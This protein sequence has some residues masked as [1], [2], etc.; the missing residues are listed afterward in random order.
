MPEP[1]WDIAPLA[2]ADCDELGRVH[3]HIWREAYAGLMP[4]EYLAGLS[5]TRCAENWRRRLEQPEG[6]DLEAMT[7][8]ARRRGR[9]VGFASAGP[10]RDDDAPTECELYVL[11]Q[12]SEVHG[13]GLADQLLDRVLGDRDASLWVVQENARARAFYARSGFVDEGGRSAHEP[14]DAAEIRMVRRGGDD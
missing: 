11:N 1:D 7:L 4:P 3:M 14:T 13:A 9:I 8:V 6:A 5:E 2:V 10:S 12:V